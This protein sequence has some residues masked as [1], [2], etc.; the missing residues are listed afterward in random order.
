MSQYAVWN[1][2][3]SRWEI[4]NQFGHIQFLDVPKLSSV[5]DI[6]LLGT[7]CLYE[8]P[9]KPNKTTAMARMLDTLNRPLYLIDTRRDGTGAQ[10]S[11]SPREFASIIPAMVRKP[12]EF[13]HLP[14]VAPSIGLLD[15]DRKARKAGNVLPWQEF[16]RQYDT[17]LTNESVDVVRAY[18]EAAAAVGGMAIILCAEPY[19]PDFDALSQ[20]HQ[21][22]LYCHRF[23]LAKRVSQAILSARC[24]KVNVRMVNLELSD[25]VKRGI[26]WKPPVTLL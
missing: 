20:E 11:W 24:G 2:E 17:G 4:I 5:V 1:E 23:T 15:E 7:R 18:V 22:E 13:L 25:F 21:E 9:V 10:S 12:L 16:K 3:A 19:C 8:I 6:G 14:A 26:S